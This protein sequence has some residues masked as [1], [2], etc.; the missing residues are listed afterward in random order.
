[1]A[2]TGAHSHNAHENYNKSDSLV[3][4]WTS[5]DPEVFKKVVFVY[6]LNSSKQG[7]W[8]NV[9]L[10]IWGPSTNLLVEST[11]LQEKVIQMKKNGVTLTSC[12]WCAEQYSA[13]EQL[14]ELG[15]EVKYMGKPLTNYLKAGREVLVF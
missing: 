13:T 4:L 6:G 14:E 11:E 5:K 15:V 8:D 7:W 3:I 12:K 10:I 1:M 2:Q 9:E